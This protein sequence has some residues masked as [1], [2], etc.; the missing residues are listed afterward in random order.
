MPVD[1]ERHQWTLNDIP[2]I[3]RELLECAVPLT[4]HLFRPSPTT[5]AIH[6]P[7]PKNTMDWGVR[8]SANL[9]IFMFL[10]SS[11]AFLYVRAGAPNSPNG[12]VH[13]T[14]LSRDVDLSNIYAQATRPLV[15]TRY[16]DAPR[17]RV[18]VITDWLRVSQAM[19]CETY[20]RNVSSI[21]AGETLIETLSPTCR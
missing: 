10:L 9:A 13:L 2:A 6:T 21:L 3:L 14:V 16:I 1:M 20:V 19:R 5:T 7:S 8:L 15:F 4:A 11:V 18:F 12:D 17:T